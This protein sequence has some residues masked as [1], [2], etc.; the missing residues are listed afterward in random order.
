MNVSSTAGV[1]TREDGLELNNTI[2]VA[3]LDSTKESVV[4]VA[5]VRRVTVSAG[6]D[7]GV[8]T[9]FT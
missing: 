6:A 4:Q 7:S 3:R 1:V 5:G 2:G 8:D 9:L